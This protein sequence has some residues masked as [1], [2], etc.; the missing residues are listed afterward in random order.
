MATL[1]SKINELSGLA[2]AAQGVLADTAVQ[3]NDS[4]VTKAWVN[5][6]HFYTN[7]V[8]DSFNVSSMTDISVGIA[9]M[10]LSSAM[11]T[12]SNYS[13]SISGEHHST[14]ILGF[15]G[16]CTPVNAA[17]CGLRSTNVNGAFFD[18]AYLFGSTHGDL[19]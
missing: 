10:N 16:F 7:S 8:R 18:N 6:D 19:A 3:P 13:V 9:T 4:S 15:A 12:S 17:S 11:S 5:Y 14:V 2:T 1:S